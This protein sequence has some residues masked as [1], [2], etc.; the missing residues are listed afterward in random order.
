MTPFNPRR[1]AWIKI[2]L[3]A[4]ALAA[5]SVLC[6]RTLGRLRLDLTEGHRYTLSP[7]CVK[8]LGHL[9]EPVDLTLYASTSA[10]RGVPQLQTHMRR[11]DELLAQMKRASG[12]KLRVHKLDPVPYSDAEQR[13]TEAGLTPVSLAGMRQ[14]YLGLVATNSTDGREVMPFL[15]PDQD[16]FLEHDLAKTIL[17]LARAKKPKIGLL[18]SLPVAGGPSSAPWSFYDDLSNLFDVTPV[19]A[20]AGELPKDLDLLLILHPRHCSEKLLGAMDAFAHTGKPVILGMDPFSFTE[21]A[22]GHQQ[23]SPYMPQPAPPGPSDLGGLLKS[24]GVHFDPAQVA[25]DRRYALRQGAAGDAG[26]RDFLALLD[27]TDDTF[28]PKSPLLQNISRLR[29]PAA[30]VLSAEAGASTRFE[31]LLTIHGGT[32]P[33][34]AMNV[35]D[36]DQWRKMFDPDEREHVLAAYVTGPAPVY[37]PVKAAPPPA[38]K[39]K[40]GKKTDAAKPPA[41]A[42][43]PKPSGDLKVLVI[44]D[45]D[46]PN[47][48]WWSAPVQMG[49]RTVGYQ[50]EADNADFLLAAVDT[51]S[52]GGDLA[53]IASRGS[54]DR[55]FTY[56]DNLR[57]EAQMREQGQLTAL[58]NKRRDT[59]RK[60]RQLR[61]GSVNANGEITLGP[62]QKK[63]LEKYIKDYADTGESLRKR[64]FELNKDVQQ[65]GTL[66]TAANA[67]GAPLLVILGAISLAAWRRK[68]RRNA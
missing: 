41:Q 27:L 10:A 24:W 14:F 7:G 23:R 36:P 51:L 63:E 55:P 1:S 64:R 8:L 13:A 44:A 53:A 2:G 62:A 38:G 5:G 54:Y 12:G 57:K 40:D 4:A 20:A 21:A 19:D 49:G 56:V 31:P 67:A 47:E 33:T 58:E 25:A 17:K 9:R 3:L 46:F 11:V 15:P 28:N 68:R 65:L 37:P 42:A 35:P 59:E 34:S 60:I 26:A 32:L 52:A 29:L 16:A 61:G 39:D 18:S 48:M 66:I 50:K 22:M 30:G 6:D 43:A 45:A